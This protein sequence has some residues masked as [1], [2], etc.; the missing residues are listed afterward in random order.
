MLVDAKFKGID[1]AVRLALSM[2]GGGSVY[3]QKIG[4]GM[5]LST[6]WSMGDMCDVRDIWDDQK[7]GRIDYDE[8]GV[9]DYP[10]QVI[11][12]YNLSERPEKFFVSFVKITKES[13]PAVG[14]WRWHKWGEYIGNKNPQCEYIH[15]EPDIDEVYTFS[16]YQSGEKP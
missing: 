8:Y 3:P 7:A 14:G 13:Q 10:Q 11:E 1:P 4:E 9:C 16:I 15:D 6:N 5:Y 12:K 2:V